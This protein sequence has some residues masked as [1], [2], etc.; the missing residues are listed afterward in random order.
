MSVKHMGVSVV[1]AVS[2]EQAL[3]ECEIR[4]IDLIISDID[5]GKG[6]LSG[7]DFLRR[8][9]SRNV[10]IPFYFLS[11]SSFEDEESK[12]KAMGATGYVQLPG[13]EAVIE[14]LLARHCLLNSRGDRP[15]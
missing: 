2:V 10:T 4:R 15:S 12:A 11:G 14:S 7:Y 1:T 9:R 5:F 8:M 3:S 6:N 13:D